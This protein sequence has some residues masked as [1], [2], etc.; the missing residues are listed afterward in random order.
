ML[1]IAIESS[2]AT[3]SVA[4]LDDRRVLASATCGM[5][6]RHNE[7]LVPAIEF[8]LA[9]SASTVADVTAVAVG[10]GPG[11]YTGMRVGMATARMFASA[12]DLPMVGV[13][14]LDALAATV[15]GSRVVVPTIDARR[16][17]VFWSLHVG[18]RVSDPEVGKVAEL[19]SQIED[20]HGPVHVVGDP[21]GKVLAD[22]VAANLP[23]VT[24]GGSGDG[25]LEQQRQE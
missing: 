3:S 24:I 19:I 21:D 12:R 17:E 6:K 23:D 14:G 2:T 7:F 20:I 10:V 16:G 18:D 1:L 9:Q 22:L 5:G 8:C 25:H 15:R 13:S 4:V 11:L